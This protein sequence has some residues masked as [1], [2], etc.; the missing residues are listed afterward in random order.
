MLGHSFFFYIRQLCKANAIK[1]LESY[2]CGTVAAYRSWSRL[3]WAQWTAQ[4]LSVWRWLFQC[5]ARP[6]CSLGRSSR[7]HRAQRTRAIPGRSYCEH[8][9]SISRNTFTASENFTPL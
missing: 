1:S 9:Q 7:K 5:T 3:E 4:R 6:H 8:N 2:M